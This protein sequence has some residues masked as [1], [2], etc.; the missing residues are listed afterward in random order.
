MHAKQHTPTITG[1]TSITNNVFGAAKQ[2]EATPCTKSYNFGLRWGYT[3]IAPNFFLQGKLLDNAISIREN[4]WSTTP[5]FP[6]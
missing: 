1:Y 6:I 2:K 4:G 5:T 3:I